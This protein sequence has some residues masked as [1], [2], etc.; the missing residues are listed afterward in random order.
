[1]SAI[2]ITGSTGLVG[3]E[4]VEFFCKKNFHVVGIDNNYRKYFF[5]KD[6]DTKWIKNRLKNKFKNY[7]HLNCDI[8]NKKKIRDIFKK[9]NSDIK[10]VIHAAGQPSHDWAIKEPFTDFSI[11]AEGTL[12]LLNNTKEF[13]RL[14]P[15]IFLSTNKVYGDNPNKFKFRETKNRYNIINK[16]FKNGFNE[17][18]NVDNCVHSLFGV[19][20]L[21]ADMLVQEYGKNIGLKTVCFRAGCITG[22]NHSGAKLHGFLSYLVKKTIKDRTYD[23]I[24]FKGKQVR[25]NI[26]SH[27][28]INCFW[29]FFLKPTS[30]KVYNI[31]GGTYSNCSILEAIDLIEKKLSIKIKKNL[32]Q[33]PRIGDHQWYISN[34]KKFSNDYKKWKQ[35]YNIEMIIENLLKEELKK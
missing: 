7:T 15:F 32:I 17:D 13:A 11:N 4:A 5:G 16:N 19:S 20:K 3:S 29:Q 18:L 10:L 25:D 31:G 9:F 23:L 12:N 2:I 6:G 14:S 33:K 30:G 21:S 1:M 26:H 24:G 22:S 8:R 27:D 34:T 35:T 28:L